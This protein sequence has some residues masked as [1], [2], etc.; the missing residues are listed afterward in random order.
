MLRRSEGRMDVIL[1]NHSTYPDADH[2]MS[3][4]PGSLDKRESEERLA[5]VLREQA[6]AGL[7]VI[8]D[9][10]PDPFARLAAGLEGVRVGERAGLLDTGQ[11]YCRPVVTGAVRRPRPIL[12]SDFIRASAMSKLPLKPV[13]PGPYTLARFSRIESAP[14][15]GVGGLAEVFSQ[16][17]AAEVQDLQRAG[18]RYIQIQEPAILAY[19]ADIRLLRSLLEPL[20]SARGAAELIVATDCGDAA[21]LYAQLNSLP[22]DIVAL[23][24]TRSQSLRDL[25]AAT[26]ASKVLALGLVDGGADALE[27]PGT[28]ARQAELMLKRY[29]LDRVHL[30]PA[31]GFHGLPRATARAK[32]AVLHHVRELVHLAG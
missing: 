24:C 17:L 8:T 2:A 11:R 7:D 30:L 9:G 22:A 6:E 12:S 20:W 29:V 27:D 25:V 31:C 4:R 28:L 10:W 21:P 18:A 1:Q 23:D 5:A 16:V 14:Y 3:Q 26:G 19:P 15:T 13:L 32:L